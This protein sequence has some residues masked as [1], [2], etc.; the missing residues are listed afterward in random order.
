[1]C[2]FQSSK[3]KLHRDVI[4]TCWP[5]KVKPQRDEKSHLD[6]FKP[7]RRAVVCVRFLVALLLHIKFVSNCRLKIFNAIVKQTFR[8]EKIKTPNYGLIWILW[9]TETLLHTDSRRLFESAMYVILKSNL[10]SQTSFQSSRCVVRSIYVRERMSA[11][12]ER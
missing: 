6:R 2:W 7:M 12:A 8:S 4:S 3:L 9:R 5:F 11:I 1:M 10:Y